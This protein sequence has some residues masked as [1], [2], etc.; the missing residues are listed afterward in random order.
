MRRFLR[1]SIPVFVVGFIAGNAF[2]YLAS[3]LWIDVVVS[4]SLPSDLVVTDVASGNFHDADAVHRG[5]GQVKIV[6]SGG[7]SN[8]L[9]LSAFEVTNGPDLKVI[10]VK[11]P[12]PQS[13]ADVKAVE[14]V[15]LGPLKGNI[16]DQNYTIPAEINPGDFGSVAIWC[17]QFGVLFAAAPLMFEGL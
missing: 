12:D 6:Q 15:S 8:I 3:P 2:W 4:E 9:T 1:I 7:G 11:A 13:S 16:G 17:K 10:L 14:W 5:A